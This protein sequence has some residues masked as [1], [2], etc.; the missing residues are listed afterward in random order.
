MGKDFGPIVEGSVHTT[1]YF[2][3]TIGYLARRED[4]D[5]ESLEIVQP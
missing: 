1:F 3:P 5:L 4:F 2:P